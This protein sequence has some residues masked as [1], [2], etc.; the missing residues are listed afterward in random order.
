MFDKIQLN[1]KLIEELKKYGYL[2]KLMT[3]IRDLFGKTYGSLDNTIGV[4][5]NYG[6]TVATSE[7]D[8]RGMDLIFKISRSLA[9]KRL[10]CCNG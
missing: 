8:I 9:K 3:S 7:G 5:G 1:R 4:F 2:T 10:H 6:T